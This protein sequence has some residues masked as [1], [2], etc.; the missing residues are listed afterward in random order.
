MTSLREV[1]GGRPIDRSAAR[2]RF[3]GRPRGRDRGAPRRPLRRRRLDRAPA[4]DRPDRPPRAARRRDRDRAGDSASTPTS[5]ALVVED[6]DAPGGDRPVLVGEV[7]PRPPGRTRREAGCNAMARPALGRVG[8]SGGGGR[9]RRRPSRSRPPRSSRRPRRT[10]PGSRPSIGSTSPRCTATPSTSSR[11]H[12]EAEDATERTFLAALTNLGRFE[13]R[14]RPGRW[15]GRVDVPR[16]AVPDRPQ[17][18]RRAAPPAA[19]PAR[20]AARGRRARSPT[21]STSSADVDAPRRG[22]AAPGGPSAGCPATGAGRWSCASSTRCRRRRSPASSAAPRAPSGSSSIAPCGASPATSA[23]RCAVTGRRADGTASEIE[24]LVTDR[25]L[26]A[27]LRPRRRA[28][29]RPAEVEPDDGLRTTAERLART[30]RGSTRRSGS[31]RP[32]RPG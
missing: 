2:G 24:A 27:L 8:P 30:C 12:H 20:G 3:V 25:Y 14:A 31:R 15:R 28:D 17:R 11:D 10:R 1:S 19:P 32:W 26:E 23:S 16:L 29:R 9:P 13:E 5:G 18:R 22:R 7:A 4:D 6:P 21:R